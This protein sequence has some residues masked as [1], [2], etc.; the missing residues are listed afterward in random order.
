MTGVS[1]RVEERSVIVQEKREKKD[2][3]ARFVLLRGDEEGQKLSPPGVHLG[4]GL[5]LLWIASR[6][7]EKKVAHSRAAAKC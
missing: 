2:E 4:V 1:H 7:I 5:S 3:S 6:W